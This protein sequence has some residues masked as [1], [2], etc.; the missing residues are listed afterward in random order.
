MW[1]PAQ[2]WPSVTIL[3]LL[4]QM[5]LIVKWEYANTELN[6]PYSAPNLWASF[7]DPSKDEISCREDPNKIMNQDN[8]SPSSSLLGLIH[9][10]LRWWMKACV[11]LPMSRSLSHSMSHT[12]PL[13]PIFVV[14]PAPCQVVEDTPGCSPHQCQQQWDRDADMLR[15]LSCFPLLDNPLPTTDDAS[16]FA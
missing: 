14:I 13:L 9:T 15:L 8:Q 2:T 10:Q 1:T 4:T 16:L 7:S 5:R 11:P 12:W 6:A 3:T